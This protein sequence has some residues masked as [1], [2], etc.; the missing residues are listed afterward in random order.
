MKKDIYE[1]VA[2]KLMIKGQYKLINQ[3]VKWMSHSLRSRTK[4]L[5]KYQSLSEEEALKEI[6]CTIQGALKTADFRK[7]YDDNLIF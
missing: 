3:N 4:S 6:V 1:E 2:K 5:M 7:Y